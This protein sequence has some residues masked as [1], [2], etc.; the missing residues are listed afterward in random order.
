MVIIF[1][2]AVILYSHYKRTCTR[3]S[4]T[5]III[6]TEEGIPHFRHVTIKKWDYPY[7][8]KMEILS[9][10]KVRILSFEEGFFI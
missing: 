10:G 7:S 1:L 6:Q 5:W 8:L 9:N 2:T 3:I 4:G